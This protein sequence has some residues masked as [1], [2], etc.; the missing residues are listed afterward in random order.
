M[1]SASESKG[2]YVYIAELAD[3]RLYV[4]MTND[5]QRR[6]SEHTSG[7]EGTRTT[8]VFGFKGILYSEFFEE[9]DAAETRERQL[10]HWS[11]T[12][13]LALASG[14]MEELKSL[15][16]RRKHPKDRAKP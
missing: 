3:G 5:L 2:Y 6:I 8:R 13:K 14:D 10:K 9:K 12:K 11:R 16:K 15:S 1:S 4:G 7:K